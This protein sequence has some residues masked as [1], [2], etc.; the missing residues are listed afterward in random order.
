MKK[1]AVYRDKESSVITS[2]QNIPTSAY[3]GLEGKMKAYNDNP[4][5]DKTVEVV[6]LNEGSL[7][8]FLYNQSKFDIKKYRDEIGCILDRVCDLCTDVDRLSDLAA[9][10][11]N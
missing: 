1:V 4:D 8:L 5:Y 9:G 3:L 6:E 2:V 10:K 11:V 7:E